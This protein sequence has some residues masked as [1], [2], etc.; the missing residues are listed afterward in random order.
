MR[1][2]NLTV[3]LVIILSGCALFP[4]STPQEDPSIRFPAF[5][6]RPATVLGAQGQPYEL[7]GVMLRAITIAADDFSPPKGGTRECWEKQEAH[8]YRVI[9]REDIIF[10]Q[11]SLD[12]AACGYAI[13]DG[14]AKYAIRS[15]D[16]RILRR[17]FDGEPENLNPGSDETVSQSVTGTPVPASQVGMTSTEIASDLPSSWFTKSSPDAGSPSRNDG[18][19]AADGGSPVP[20]TTPFP[21]DAGH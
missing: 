12:S 8:R 5:H 2:K 19:Q 4:K 14:G 17:L 10:V 1:T 21:S 15:S 11:I 6:E 16:G 9:R 7:D 3:A 20:P 18:G 13:L